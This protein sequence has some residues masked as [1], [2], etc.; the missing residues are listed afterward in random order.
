MKIGSFFANLVLLLALVLTG[1]ALADEKIVVVK[2]DTLWRIAEKVS[3]NP[4]AYK[5]YDVRSPKG[6]IRANPDKIYPGDAVIIPAKEV[7][8]VA[9]EVTPAKTISAFCSNYRVENCARELAKINRKP[10][11]AVVKNLRVPLAFEKI[12]RRP[13]E[14]AMPK[15]TAKTAGQPKETRNHRVALD[16]QNMPYYLIFV[17]MLLILLLTPV[18]LPRMAAQM[19]NHIFFVGRLRWIERF[20]VARSRLWRVRKKLTE[21]IK[22]EQINAPPDCNILTFQERLEH[23]RKHH[24]HSIESMERP[25]PGEGKIMVARY[26]TWILRKG[27]SIWIAPTKK[28]RLPSLDRYKRAILQRENRILKDDCSCGFIRHKRPREKW[29]WVNFKLKKGVLF[30]YQ[31]LGN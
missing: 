30:S 23:F 14:S 19:E 27:I 15:N 8:T 4:L 5:K 21:E 3:I 22:Q 17:A 26:R 1:T 20:N 16:Y 18:A 25:L 9:V 7:R 24:I 6:K 13:I 28:G 31:F 11:H 2:G 12:D 29:R 10:V